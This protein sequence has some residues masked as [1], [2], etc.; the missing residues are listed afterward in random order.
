MS[1]FAGT[2]NAAQAYLVNDIYLK[3]TRPDATAKQ[4]RNMNYI[5]GIVVVV[6]AVQLLFLKPKQAAA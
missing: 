3:Y 2:L 4:L 1:T 5:T 6:I